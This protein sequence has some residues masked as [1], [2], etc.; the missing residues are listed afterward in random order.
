MNAITSAP[1][2]FEIVDAAPVQNAQADE[3]ADLASK[4]NAAVSD[5][6]RAARIA[7]A[8]ALEAG[9]MLNQ[10]KAIVKHG[11][12]KLWVEENCVLALR[13][14]QAYMRFA[15]GYKALAPEEAQR[16]ALLPLREAIGAIGMNP[17]SPKRTPAVYVR[18]SSDRKGMV[19]KS[20]D[21]VQN[22]TRK[23]RKTFDYGPVP[24]KEIAAVR[25]ELN[26]VLKLID[27]ITAESSE[28][29][30]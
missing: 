27:E 22:A 20:I 26:A 18:I 10:A 13:T 11:A 3:L 19:K 1:V 7:V 8:R 25:A 5:A 15:E 6:E 12:W 21:R 4:I 29:L 9:A 17:E 23:L 24:E 14:A 30:Q 2:E 16:V 28:G